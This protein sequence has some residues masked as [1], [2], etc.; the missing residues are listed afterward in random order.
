MG[1]SGI[2]GVGTNGSSSGTRSKA[3]HSE[4]W[5]DDFTPLQHAGKKIL[6][7]LRDDES[8]AHGDLYRRIMSST[9]AAAAA[10]AATSTTTAMGGSGGAGGGGGSPDQDGVPNH[11][12]FQDNDPNVGFRH[13]HSIPLPPYLQEQLPKAKVSTTM[14]LFPQAELAWMTIDDCIYLWAY[15]RSTGSVPSQSQFLHFKTPTNQ[16][17]ISVGLAPP[18][19]GKLH[20]TKPSHLLPRDANNVFYFPERRVIFRL[21]AN[22]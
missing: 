15:T 21:C 3:D 14:G 17:I 20:H 9:P 5:K 13:K 6:S 19:E 22:F 11:H 7:I 4:F 2:G 12:Y 1:G 8:S 18:K 10:A 16:P